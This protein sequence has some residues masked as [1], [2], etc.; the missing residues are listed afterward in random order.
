MR[1]NL[2][3]PRGPMLPVALILATGANLGFAPNVFAQA[4]PRPVSLRELSAS[5]E[6]LAARVRPAVV[7]IFSTG[8]AASEESD[9]TA[10]SSLLSTQRST[11]SGVILTADGY[12]VTNNHVVQGARKIEVRLPSTQPRR[13]SQCDASPRSWSGADRETDLA[14]I[15]I[16][17]TDLPFL[18]LG[19]SNELQQGQ[20]GDGVRQSA[21]PGRVGFD[22][23][24]QL[25][26]AAPEA[27]KIRMVYVQTDAPINPGNSGGPLVDAEGRVVGHQHL[28]PYAVGRQRRH[29]IRGAQQRGPEH[30]RPDPQGRARASRADRDCRPDHHAGHGEGSEAFAGLGRGCVAM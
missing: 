24:R 5:F 27:R 28:H 1:F 11:G 13:G 20:A 12:I 2:I 9:G 15:K 29:R 25:G 19:D 8:Y 3:L 22:G 17:R 6:E 14:V 18:A 21:G 10:A 23:D 7:Q 30:L 26:F 4:S 16:D